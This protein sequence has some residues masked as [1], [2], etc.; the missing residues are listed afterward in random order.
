MASEWLVREPDGLMDIRYILYDHEVSERR[1]EQLLVWAA[2]D[3][4]LK[5]VRLIL[6]V[7]KRAGKRLN[8]DSCAAVRD[9]EIFIDEKAQVKGDV[10]ALFA[11]VT[12][13][14]KPHD[15]DSLSSLF[16]CLLEAKANPYQTVFITDEGDFEVRTCVREYLENIVEESKLA[17]LKDVELEGRKILQIIDREDQTSFS[18]M[19]LESNDNGKSFCTDIFNTRD[20]IVF[21]DDV[22]RAVDNTPEK[23]ESLAKVRPGKERRESVFGRVKRK[24]WNGISRKS[25]RNPVKC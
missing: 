2:R 14:G 3:L 13:I 16:T 9:V 25:R 15:P 19:E 18:L 21:A 8:I 22:K 1:Y 11:C 20:E 24:V 23:E 4:R 12:N 10:P 6:I 17:R 7:A 5:A